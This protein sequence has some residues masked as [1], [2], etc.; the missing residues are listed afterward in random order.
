MTAVMPPIFGQTARRIYFAGPLGFSEA[1]I[2]FSH[3]VLIPELERSGHR[4]INPFDL[5]DKTK[6]DAIKAM[7]AADH[8][9]QAWQRFNVNTG[10]ENRNAIDRC[11]IVF[12]VLDGTDVNSGTAAEIGYAFARNKPVLGYR[13]DSR[14]SSDNE[15][16]KVNLQVEYFIRASGGDIVSRV[17]DIADAILRLPKRNQ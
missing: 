9:I 13:G 7:P 11:D 10:Q 17:L 4:V 14:L 15:G 2:N 1:G 5:H 8:R 16:G 12:A 6:I 3:A